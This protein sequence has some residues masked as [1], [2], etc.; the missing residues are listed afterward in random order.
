LL[1]LSRGFALVLEGDL[2][3]DHFIAGVE[4]V[5]TVDMSAPIEEKQVKSNPGASKIPFIKLP[6]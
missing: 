5:C 1:R 6:F 2:F 3:H 4:V